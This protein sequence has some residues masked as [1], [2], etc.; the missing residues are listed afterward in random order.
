MPTHVVFVCLIL[1]V[2]IAAIL[3]LGSVIMIAEQGVTGGALFC[4]G[5]AAVCG[6]TAY[7]INKIRRYLATLSATPTPDP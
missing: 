7:V 3:S 2:A 6:Y 1:N 4:L 5:V